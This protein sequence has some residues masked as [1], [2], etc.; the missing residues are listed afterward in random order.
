MKKV[1][2]AAFVYD[3][4][5]II[6]RCLRRLTESSREFPKVSAGQSPEG[7]LREVREHQP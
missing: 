5:E 1:I 6:L 2:L 3:P 4:H 7:S